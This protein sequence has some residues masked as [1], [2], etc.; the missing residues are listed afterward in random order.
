MS[1][2]RTLT[3]DDDL[4]LSRVGYE[5]GEV[6]RPDTGS[7]NAHR[8]RVDTA[9]Q[10]RRRRARAARVDAR[11]TAPP[12]PRHQP[13]RAD[14][15]RPAA[16]PDPAQGRRRPSRRPARAAAVV[17]RRRPPTRTRTS[18]DLRDDA[19]D[20]DLLDGVDFAVVGVERV[21]RR[22]VHRVRGGGRT[23]SASSY[24]DAGVDER[25]VHVAGDGAG[26]G[27]VPRRGVLARRRA[28]ARD[29]TWA[30]RRPSA[31]RTGPR[32][33]WSR[34]TSAGCSATTQTASAAERPCARR[35]PTLD[36]DRDD[37]EH[38]RADLGDR[39]QPH[40][41]AD[42]LLVH[43]EEPAGRRRD[44]ERGQRRDAEPDR[45]QQRQ[46]VPP[47]EHQDAEHDARRRR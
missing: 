9:Q 22:R 33:R 46:P 41:D 13:A 29:R 42:P 12:V 36:D 31:P 3:V 17:R 8:Y 2:V 39:R 10:P 15:P 34:R 7:S 43:P 30:G 1:A 21:G 37:A 40:R 4:A 16:V 18:L 45:A 35:G 20:N 28:R 38:D 24:R 47:D 26:A 32:R 25:P 11:P 44:E 5:R 14:R 6:L 23:G 27:R 19:L